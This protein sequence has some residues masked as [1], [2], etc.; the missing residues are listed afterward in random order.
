MAPSLHSGRRSS[1]SH[2]TEAALAQAKLAGVFPNELDGCRLAAALYF[3][4]GAALAAEAIIS[5]F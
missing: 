2:S 4:F 3:F 5:F 1:S